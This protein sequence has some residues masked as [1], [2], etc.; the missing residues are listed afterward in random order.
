MCTTTA[1]QSFHI[2][3]Y[4]NY[5]VI[6]SFLPLLFSLQ[7]CLYL[8]LLSF[9]F[10]AF[11]LVHEFSYIFVYACIYILCVNIYIY[12]Y[13]YF[14]PK[15]TNTICSVYIVMLSGF[16]FSGLAVWYWITIWCDFLRKDTISHS[17]G[18]HGCSNSSRVETLN[19]IPLAYHLLK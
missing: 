19:Y 11:F 7:P 10:V 2:Y 12:K 6:T 4:F 15:C 16:V 17:S 5:S 3:V 13:I 14:F 8:L 1:T 9:R 18:F